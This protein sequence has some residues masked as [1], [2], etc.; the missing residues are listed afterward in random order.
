MYHFSCHAIVIL[1]F[2]NYIY[3]DIFF[4]H[5]RFLSFIFN[6]NGAMETAQWLR[7]IIPF[8]EDWTL[9]PSTHMGQLS[10]ICNFSSG[11]SSALSCPLQ[12]LSCT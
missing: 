6:A 12:A 1:S 2:P 11:G 5:A 9:I 3:L 10:T 8:P 7:M 4:K